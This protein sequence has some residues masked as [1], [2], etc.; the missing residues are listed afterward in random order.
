[1]SKRRNTIIA[2]FKFTRIVFE[3]IR[4]PETLLLFN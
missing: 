4:Y 1:M 3:N 2:V